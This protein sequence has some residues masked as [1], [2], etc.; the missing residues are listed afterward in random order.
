MFFHKRYYNFDYPSLHFQTG[1]IF[2]LCLVRLLF[3]K[4]M[5]VAICSV[6]SIR[7]NFYSTQSQ[8][9]CWNWDITQWTMESSW[10]N[11][12]TCLIF[13]FTSNKEKHL[14]SNIIYSY[15]NF[16]CPVCIVFSLRF[17]PSCSLIISFYNAR[18][19]VSLKAE[20]MINKKKK[21][22]NYI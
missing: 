17:C 14:F 3:F 10:D 6:Y 2:N 12:L 15:S 1:R 21:Q 19:E 4:L 18:I 7:F 9:W 16:W 5:Y 22:D 13:C 20:V 8:Q 11:T